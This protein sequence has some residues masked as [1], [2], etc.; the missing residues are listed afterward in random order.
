VPLP[1]KSWQTLDHII[2]FGEY[3]EEEIKQVMSA[4]L[5]LPLFHHVM[6]DFRAHSKQNQALQL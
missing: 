1:G 5:C 4:S 3:Y 6:D 2:G